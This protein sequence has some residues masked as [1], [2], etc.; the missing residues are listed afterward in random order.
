MRVASRGTTGGARKV[1]GF[2]IAEIRCDA[3]TRVGQNYD[4]Q[5]AYKARPFKRFV[6]LLLRPRHVVNFRSLHRI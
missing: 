3:L 6:H 4:S 1:I 5:G 2:V